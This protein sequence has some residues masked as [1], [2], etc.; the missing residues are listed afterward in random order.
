MD[1]AAAVGRSGRVIAVDQ[2]PRFLS[3]LATTAR[4]GGFEQVETVERDLSVSGPPAADADM[5]W[6]RW[7]FAFVRDPKDLVRR[8]HRA[9]RPGGKLVVHEYFNYDTWRMMPRCAELE[10]FVARVM[11][12]WRAHG[13]EPNAAVDLPSSMAEA[14]FTVESVRPHVFICSPQDQMWEWPCA[15]VRGGLQRLVTI[16]DLSS[17]EGTRILEGFERAVRRPG[18]RMVTPAVAEILARKYG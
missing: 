6:C 15:F 10:T 7:I 16:G 3:H 1:L 14:G 13:G 4:A 8:I 18:V 17:G 2:S 12:S 11:E 5:A 9:L